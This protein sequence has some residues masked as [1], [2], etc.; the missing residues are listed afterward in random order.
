MGIFKAARGSVGGVLADSWLE[1]YSCA[2]L[3]AG[4]LA[5]RASKQ[6]SDRSANTKGEE[7]VISD[8][9]TIIVNAG[10][11]A[12]AI[13]KGEV[14]GVYDQ[15]GENTYHTERSPSIFHKG[16][17]KGV[18][19]QSFDRFG[20]GGVAAVYQAIVFLDM[21]EHLGNPFSLKTAIDLTDRNTGVS[22]DATLMMGGVFSF[23]IVK[24]AVFY[25][26][27]C[28]CSTGTV[29]LSTIL[30]QITA[31][32][33]MLLRHAIAD[34]CKEGTTA[35]D[36]SASSDIIC[37]GVISQINEQWTEERGFAIISVGIDETRLMKDDL[38]LLQSV[39][40]A[41]ALSDPKL[42]A[43]T[44]VGAQAQAMQDAAKNRAPIRVTFNH[45]PKSY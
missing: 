36:L 15:L 32:L 24:P 1:S 44:L 43:A 38:D 6:T 26:K 27:L 12:L 3:P 16:G 33:I 19:K 25:K 18:A 10:Q 8:G 4:V 28:G 5:Q 31:E 34:F 40:M 9:S 17:L 20:Y 13:D 35:Y 42:A 29:M 23:T 37:D 21:R 41:R 7:N 45:T 22:I 39:Q 30:P 11:C 14:T 2:A